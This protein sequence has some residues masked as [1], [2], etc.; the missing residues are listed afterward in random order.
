VNV[1]GIADEGERREKGST[2]TSENKGKTIQACKK[3]GFGK[4]LLSRVI[5][6]MAREGRELGG[7]RGSQ[8]GGICASTVNLL[9][10]RIQRL[11]DERESPKR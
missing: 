10:L 2:T 4:L 7:S 11:L 1:A 5:G 8:E 3:A 6:S 9:A